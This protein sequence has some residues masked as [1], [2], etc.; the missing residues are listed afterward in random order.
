MA[1][2]L[3]EFRGEIEVEADC[4]LE[5]ECTA[6]FECGPDNCRVVSCDAEGDDFFYD[7]EDKDN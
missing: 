2:Y 7:D 5:A 3:V 1:K 4:E 6:A